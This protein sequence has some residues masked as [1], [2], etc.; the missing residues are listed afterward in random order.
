MPSAF[1]AA[2]AAGK[3]VTF[4]FNISGPSGGDWFVVV[5][6]GACNVSTG[7][8]D[9]PTTTIGMADTDFVDLIT[10]KLDGMKAFTAGK[11]KV[12]GDM[13]KSQLIGKLFKF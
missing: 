7:K 11:L 4:Q 1:N 13:M 3:D 12:T 5:K 2:A 10:G 6:D 9:S 8:V